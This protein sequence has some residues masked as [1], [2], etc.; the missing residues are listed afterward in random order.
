MAHSIPKI[1]PKLDLVLERI[2]DVPPELVW[3]SWTQPEHLMKWFTPVPWKTVECEIDLRPGGTFRTVMQSPEGQNFPNEGCYLEV[4][5]NVR[6]VWTSALLPGFRPRKSKSTCG[7]DEVSAF[8]AFILLEP[9][10]PGGQGTKYTA[11]VIHSDE[12]GRAAH[13]KMGFHEGWGTALDQ[14]VVAAKKMKK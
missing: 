13:E 11:V 7:P 1:D 2:V 8:T 9:S 3:A 10:G 4:V 5:E 12:E 6:L 14:L